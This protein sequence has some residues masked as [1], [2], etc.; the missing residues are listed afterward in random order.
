LSPK[1]LEDLL[2]HCYVSYYGFLLKTEGLSDEEQRIA[3]YHRYTA[4]QRT[5]PM[6]G[7]VDRL[8]LDSA[9]DYAA[10]RRAAFDI[11]LVPLPDSLSLSGKDEAL[12]R[13]ID[14]RVQHP[15]EHATP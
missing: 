13:R 9:T 5:H 15:V 14:W 8:R 12:N 11:D 2:Y 4:A 6:S 10:L 7:G 3:I 1:R